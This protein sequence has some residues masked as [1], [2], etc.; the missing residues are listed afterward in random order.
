MTDVMERTPPVGWYPES[1]DSTVLRW[2]D[3]TAWTDHV[4][5]PAQDAAVNGLRAEPVAA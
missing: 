3:G 2:W 5:D 4:Q 1:P